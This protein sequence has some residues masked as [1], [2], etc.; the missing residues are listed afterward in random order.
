MTGLWAFEGQMPY[1]VPRTSYSS[2]IYFCPMLCPTTYC[3][4]EEK[5]K[6]IM[7]SPW[8]QRNK[9][10]KKERKYEA[11]FIRN[12]TFTSKKRKEK[13]S[14]TV[15]TLYNHSILIKSLVGRFRDF[16]GFLPHCCYSVPI[17]NYEIQKPQTAQTA[18]YQD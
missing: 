18:K 16:I 15:S 1:Q 5:R 13:K 2:L 12:K 17:T 4:S 9:A 8:C 10:E 3:S 11:W 6:L 14:Q 7:F